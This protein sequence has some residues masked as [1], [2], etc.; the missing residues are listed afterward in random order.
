MR[1]LTAAALAASLFTLAI[2]QVPAMAMQD[3]T[4]TSAAAAQ[5]APAPPTV[6]PAQDAAAKDREMQRLIG[7][8]G[9]L[10]TASQSLQGLNPDDIK[11]VERLRAD[12]EMFNVRW[13]EEQRMI[14]L[15]LQ[16]CR[17]LGNRDCVDR[18][19]YQL[20]ELNPDTPAMVIVW[21]DD[22]LGRNEYQRA[23]DAVDLWHQ[24]AKDVPALAFVKAKC[25]FALNRFEEA[26]AAVAEVQ[27]S[28]SIKPEHQVEL[29]N[30][31]QNASKY[32]ELW[33]EELAKREAEAKA[34]DLP[35]VTIETE[36]GPITIELFE[37]DAPIA[38][39]NFITLVEDGYFE[40]MTFHRVVRN[41]VTQTGD[42]NSKPGGEGVVGTGG[43]GYR[44]ADEFTLPGARNHFAGSVGMAH[45]PAPNSA[46][47]Q[48]YIMHEPK[49]D[50]NGKYTV[51]G[52]VTEGLEIARQMKQGEKLIRAFVV[53]KRSHPY[54]NFEKLTGDKQPT[55]RDVEIAS[56]PAMPVDPNTTE[57]DAAPKPEAPKAEEP[58]TTPEE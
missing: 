32:V 31:R 41:H 24:P 7:A 53:R 50:L 18:L 10:L 45:G 49:P 43:P 38:V 14:A 20:V 22:L 37:N 16:C 42:P 21:S 57:G 2:P 44:I 40:D 47:S 9:N 56:P 39:A 51:F 28:P 29:L 4:A 46:G 58:A 8:F 48:F 6:D 3:G 15:E 27:D 11:Q 5:D 54:D 55:A 30:L 17:W 26:A 13:P 35:I 34:D 33:S 12:L 23:L 36:R 1:N 52:R 19:F 25:L